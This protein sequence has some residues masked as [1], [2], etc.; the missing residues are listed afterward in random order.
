MEHMTK[1]E[2]E[3]EKWFDERMK[4]I[5]KM[6]GVKELEELEGIAFDKY[7]IITFIEK[8]ENKKIL[9]MILSLC[10]I[11]FNK[12]MEKNKLNKGDLKTWIKN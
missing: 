5:K 10:R 11:E 3:E 12:T 7:M 4:M 6:L 8:M 1:E 9:D 2:I